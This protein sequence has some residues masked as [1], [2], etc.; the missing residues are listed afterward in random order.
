VVELLN[1]ETTTRS[2]QVWAAATHAWPR[3]YESKAEHLAHEERP[4]REKEPAKEARRALL[5]ELA[6]AQPRTAAL[7]RKIGQQQVE[8][9][10][11]QQAL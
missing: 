8:L 11:L 1:R 6:R 3:S 10:F 9:D 7:E 4:G 5:E 2:S